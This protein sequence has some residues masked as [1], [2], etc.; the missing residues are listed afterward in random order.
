MT[1]TARR[2]A[3][4]VVLLGAL[5]PAG[6]LHAQIGVGTW[7]RK[8]T[9]SMPGQHDDDGRGLLQWRSSMTYHINMGGTPTIMTL[10]SPF[11][12]SEVAVIV[13]GNPAARPWRSPAWTTIT[14]PPS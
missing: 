5:G 12:G 10:A 8:S 11:D 3:R 9:D 1:A 13:A 14:L 7:V 4:S 2:L 6:P